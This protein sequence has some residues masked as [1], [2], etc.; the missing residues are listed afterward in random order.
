MPN[1]RDFI[2][3]E[4]LDLDSPN[5]GLTARS[6]MDTAR[7]LY[8]SRPASYFTDTGRIRYPDF[9][10]L[11]KGVP[12]P[13]IDAEPCAREPVKRVRPALPEGIVY[14][15][16]DDDHLTMTDLGRADP[17]LFL[18]KDHQGNTIAYLYRPST[19]QFSMCPNTPLN[20]ESITRYYAE[21][22]RLHI[23]LTPVSTSAP[24]YH[25]DPHGHPW[26]NYDFW[27]NNWLRHVEHMV[28]PS[29]Q[30]PG[31][32]TYYQNAE[33]RARGIRTPI[34]PSRYLNKFFSDILKPEEINDFGVLWATQTM[35]PEL[36]VTQDADE[37]ETVYRGAYL[38]SC[39]HFGD[40]G[41]SGP[42]HP[43]RVYAGPDLGIAY[44][45]DTDDAAARCLVWP[46]KK[47]YY[48]KFYGDFR[49]M[50][51]ALEAAGYSD[52]SEDDFVGSRLQ[53]IEYRKGF[54]APYLDFCAYAN[55]DGEFLVTS[56]HGRIG[57]RNTNGLSAN[58]GYTCSYT[59]ELYDEEDD[60]TYVDGYGDV[61]PDALRDYFFFD[62][63]A[64]EYFHRDNLH[65]ETH[66]DYP[67]ARST[68]ARTSIYGNRFFYDAYSFRYLPD[69]Y[70]DYV[71]MADGDL[72]EEH[73]F[74]QHG[75]T[76]DLTDGRYPKDEVV[77][78]DNGMTIALDH[79][80]LN[81]PE[82]R[83]LAGLEPLEETSE[84]QVAA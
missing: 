19:G 44:I 37:I 49:R 42:C 20:R 76:C 77:S 58:A 43:A 27:R 74:F 6:L 67:I 3:I 21:T 60:L 10:K 62:V 16:E 24:Y 30:H 65:R 29:A 63:I 34:K 56:Y 75:K 73:A 2:D 47:L 57:C 17:S 25:Q 81:N 28:Q 80:D 66:P 48:P 4:T 13:M 39:M 53:R 79:Y 40:G 45:G 70:F 1:I 72:W 7:L 69:D 55:D 50:R 46:D 52:G 5:L 82:V 18:D 36:R 64:E 23:I 26:A 51:L 31:Y 38:G 9:Q 22:A 15:N 84:E 54:V 33:K 12:V 68:I 71:V 32:V 8:G 11:P 35:P 83:A 14:V 78:C 61:G 41:W 59:G